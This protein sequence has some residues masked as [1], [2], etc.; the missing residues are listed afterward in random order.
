MIRVRTG[1]PVTGGN[2]FDRE[3]ETARMPGNLERGNVL[4]LAPRRVG[5]TSLILRAQEMAPSWGYQ[6]AY[7]TAAKAKDE[8]GFV[9]QLVKAARLIPEA[10]SVVRQIEDGLLA[11]LL[12]RVESVEAF[13]AGVSLRAAH[14][15][16]W[17]QVGE[18]L[19]EGLEAVTGQRWLFMVDEL[20]VFVL[21][22]LRREDG[23]E[24]VEQFLDWFRSLRQ[25]S[26]TTERVRWVLAGSIGLDTV[27]ARLGLGDTINDLHVVHLGS[28]DRDTADAFIRELARSYSLVLPDEARGR[29]LDRIGWLIP[30]HLQI[31]FGEL[32]SLAPNDDG[33]RTTADTLYEVSVA[34]I[35]T[36]VEALL[37]PAKRGFYFDYWRQR[38][39]E[40]LGK[41]D[42]GLARRL[43]GAAA[44][45]P[46]GASK[47]TLSQ[48]LTSE[49]GDAQE[50]SER[51]R[52]LLDVLERDGYWVEADGRYRFRSPLAQAYWLARVVA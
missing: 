38:L 8:T 45:D 14:E 34:E 30:F 28:F 33:S 31:A 22:L 47:Q 27:T 49:L 9:E 15:S 18:A 42:N 24:R 48:L 46:E 4:M 26:E 21:K 37:A 12:K 19:I 3:T 10:K 23:R 52:F 43:L 16:G 20:P 50:R 7:L 17:T 39:D 25:Q 2:F 35:D 40:E 36:A 44:R 6:A 29:L 13:K 41:P 11:R 5:K 51:L 1:P 32:L